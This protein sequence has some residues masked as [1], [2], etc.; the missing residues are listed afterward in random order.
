MGAFK[1][2]VQVITFAEK[3]NADALDQALR[4]SNARGLIFNP[5]TAID[6]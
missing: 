4:K 3:D 2:G 1:A 5:E 6:S